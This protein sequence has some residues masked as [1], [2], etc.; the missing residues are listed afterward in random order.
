MRVENGLTRTEVASFRQ[1]W[2]N[3]RYQDVV[4]EKTRLQT[5]LDLLRQSQGT[6]AAIAAAVGPVSAE[7]QLMK[8]NL[9]NFIN[10]YSGKTASNG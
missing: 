8:S 5:E 10:T 6:Q 7:L 9:Q 1:A 2:E 4:A 3:A